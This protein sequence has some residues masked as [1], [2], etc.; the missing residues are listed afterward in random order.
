LRTLGARRE[1][2]RREAK[3]EARR[4]GRRGEERQRG[5]RVIMEPLTQRNQFASPEMEDYLAQLSRIGQQQKQVE[6][7]IRARFA[8]AIAN[9]FERRTA[10]ELISLDEED[11]RLSREYMRLLDLYTTAALDERRG[12]LVQAARKAGKS[13]IFP[14]TAPTPRCSVVVPNSLFLNS[15]SPRYRVCRD[16][17]CLAQ[18]TC[19]HAVRFALR[20]S[21]TTEDQARRPASSYDPHCHAGNQAVASRASRTT[22]SPGACTLCPQP[23]TSSVQA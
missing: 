3:R 4:G 7:N 16:R 22:S 21:P 13:N 9:G 12:Q 19:V 10:D 20:A 6:A 15:S 2:R 14:F 5:K 1:K 23:K 8:Q 17:E 11:E 18:L